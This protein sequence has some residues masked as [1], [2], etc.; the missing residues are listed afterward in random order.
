M[1]L[2]LWKSEKSV[3]KT[4][5]CPWVAP[6]HMQKGW[7][8]VILLYIRIKEK[9]HVTFWI[10]E[11]KEISHNL[12]CGWFVSTEDACPADAWRDKVRLLCF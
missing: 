8:E 6:V 3:S 2:V 1:L 7:F 12:D 5:L 11:G 4:A 9:K 10:A